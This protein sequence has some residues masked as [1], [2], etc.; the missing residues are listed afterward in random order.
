MDIAFLFPGQGAQFPGMARDLHD[1]SSAVRELFEAASEIAKKSLADLLFDGTDED[2]KQTDNTQIAITLANL[3]A[4][5]VLGEFGI[6]SA[7]SAGFS[8][9]E[10]AALVDAGVLTA[11]DAFHLVLHRGTIMEQVSRSLDDENGAAGMAAAMGKDLPEIQAILAETAAA[12]PAVADTYPSLYNSPLQTVIGGR[13]AALTAA[14]DALKAAGV[15]RVIPLK[16]SG[17]FHTPL[18]QPARAQFS[19][20]A[21]DVDYRD[22]GHP[23]YSNVTGAPIES[24]EEA[25]ALC[26]DQLVQTVLW[27]TEERRILADGAELLLE[28]GPGTVLQGLWNAIGKVDDTWP[29]DRFRTAGTLPEIEAIAKEIRDAD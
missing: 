25:R 1:H 21:C 18:M 13:A 26:L 3:A 23:V 24:G 5:T 9:G 4:R 6:T 2:L 28:V 16:V 12:A 10:Y 7:R 14:A 22:P 27:T 17:P 15:R 11:A 20:I 19:D 8:L 29:T